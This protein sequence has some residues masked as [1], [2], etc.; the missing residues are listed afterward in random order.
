MD[1]DAVLAMAQVLQRTGFGSDPETERTPERF[2][3]FLESLQ[4]RGPPPELV[5]LATVSTDPV[6]LLEIPFHSLCAHHLLPF[7]GHADIAYRPE[8]RLVGLG[9]LVR[10]LQHHA[11]GPQLQ[12]RLGSLLADAMFT[13]LGARSVTVRLT[14]RHLCMEMRGAH[15]EGRVVTLTSRGTPDPAIDALIGPAVNDTRSEGKSPPRPA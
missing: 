13:E 6:A 9:N 15:S 3:E 12:E 11:M 4:H 10:R 7:F 2:V 5:P 1:P 14:A 8:G